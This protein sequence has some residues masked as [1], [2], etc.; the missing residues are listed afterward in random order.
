VDDALAGRLENL[1]SD[2]WTAAQVEARR[3]TALSWIVFEWT[4]N[5]TRFEPLLDKAGDLG[6]QAVCDIVSHEHD[7]RLALGAPG[8]RD[9][10]AVRIG[11]AW[12]AGELIASAWDQGVSLRVMSSAGL[13]LGSAEAEVTLHG[14]DFELLRAMT[15][16]RSV[17]QLAEMKWEGEFERALP[18][19]WLPLL[20]P[21]AERIDE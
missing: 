13:D 21:A 8:A 16:R 1:G 19:F 6:R 2:E 18:A 14:D 7:I 20:R 12:V 11:L 10:D 4:A 3:D 17:E 5:A 15:G 9:S